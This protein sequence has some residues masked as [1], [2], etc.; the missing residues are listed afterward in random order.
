MK[1]IKVFHIVYSLQLGGAESVVTNYALH[2]N[3]RIYEP[4]VVALTEGGPLHEDLQAAGVKTYILGK[5]VGFDP[6]VIFKLARIM[7]EEGVEIVHVHTPLANNWGVPAALL[8]R[9][10]TVIRTEHGLIRRER[11]FYV[12]VNAILGLFNRRILAVSNRA[13][14]V[15]VTRDPL[16]RRK[17]M[18]VYNGIDVGRY[19]NAR[20]TTLLRTELGLPEG[21]PVV[22][23]IGSLIPLKGHRDFLK[24]AELIART[25]GEV[26]FLVVG[27]GPLRHELES[28][29]RTR[30]LG[31]RVIFTGARRDIPELLSLMDVFV[32]SSWSE[33]H[34][35]TILEAMAAGKPVV[36]TDVG[37][38]PESV[39]HGE[40]GF[41]V[42]PEDGE[43]LF[44]KVKKL[45][46]VAE[47]E[48]IYEEFRPFR[49]RVLYVI[50]QLGIG[51][52]EKQL[53]Y[54]VRGLDRRRYR[55]AVVSLSSGGYWARAL[56]SEGFEV[57]E[58]VRKKNVELARLIK[59]LGV[60]IRF[61]PK[62]V[63]TYLSSA[64]SYGRFAAA[65]SRV[66]IKITSER[67]YILPGG[68]LFRFMD[69][70]L[71]RITDAVIC[72]SKANVRF[73]QQNHRLHS[74]VIAI[75]NGIGLLEPNG[76][77]R[78]Q[79]RSEFGVGPN[80]LAVGTIGNLTPPKNHHF[81]LK[82][83]R[84][85]LHQ[86]SLKDRLHFIIVGGG[87]L[88]AELRE[89]ALSLGIESRVIFAGQREN[90]ADYLRAFD[91]FIMT[92]HYEG[93]SNAIMEAMLCA[94]ACVVTD[95]GGN[96]ELVTEGE[97]GYVVPA[98]DRDTFAARI[99]ALLGDPL[100]RRTLGQR[101]AKRILN[102]FSLERMVG[103]TEKKY[104]ELLEAKL[105]K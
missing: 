46:M 102:E 66:P 42:P 68:R 41:T 91:V 7:R 97:T 11:Q 104:E 3:R 79:L 51:G 21:T 16:S 59:L 9:V 70:Q 37:G 86:P 88:E 75:Q 6:R 25:R 28:M 101:G 67:T 12:F 20:D 63:H 45:K 27:E 87:S 90:A 74:E 22:G 24:M 43:K 14:E 83:A 77:D 58:L 52:A 72:N 1:R 47:T 53:Y 98:G 35:L 62:I 64:N 69:S 32:L 99:G 61:R 56:R 4:V 80:D 15:H 96:N 17:Y 85:L 19:Q 39:V 100:L 33:A 57:T 94:L 38:N 34:P 65:L 8:S 54:L 31:D 93:L 30:G 40:T 29:A 13:K 73:L 76:L 92:S 48:A 89:L 10:R 44:E 50:G 95:V 26:R 82:V 36:A 81:L 55:P 49:Q 2:H 78:D 105:E 60:M 5:R 103:E 71:S 84:T 23:I 18:T